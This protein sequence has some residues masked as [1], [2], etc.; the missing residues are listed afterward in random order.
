MLHRDRVLKT[1]SRNVCGWNSW[2]DV[3]WITR[4]CNAF[5]RL[6]NTFTAELLWCRTLDDR[7]ICHFTL[8][9]DVVPFKGSASGCSMWTGPF[10]PALDMAKDLAFLSGFASRQIA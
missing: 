4:D 3:L 1:Q 10:A 6:L 5:F 9:L 2:S 8:A 7:R